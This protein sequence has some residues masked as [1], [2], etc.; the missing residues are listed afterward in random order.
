MAMTPSDRRC[1]H[2]SILN[3]FIPS[4]DAQGHL[5]SPT[6]LVGAVLS[7]PGLPVVGVSRV[8]LFAL[9]GGTEG[10]TSSPRAPDV[11]PSAIGATGVGLF[12]DASSD[13]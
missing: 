5:D 13:T 3:S 6:A 7:V 9:A 11:G 8:D 1:C 2:Q 12:A 10:G 4:F